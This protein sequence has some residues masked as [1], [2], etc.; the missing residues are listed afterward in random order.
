M[1]E[2]L[3]AL[4]RVRKD[5]NPFMQIQNWIKYALIYNSD[6][7][8]VSF[9]QKIMY[10]YQA[11]IIN[12]VDGDT[13][14]LEIDLGFNVKKTERIRLAR[15]DTCEM[16]SEIPFRRRK[17]RHAKMVGKKFC[18]NGSIV[19]INTFKIKIDMYA[20]YI[21]EVTFNKKNLSDYLIKQ[22]V[23]KVVF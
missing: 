8:F 17:A 18:P 14:V 12:W 19:E 22:G 7:V 11:K 20:R 10:L 15:I 23:A 5:C 9:S 4:I 3:R 1:E 13:L 6:F 16:R 21:A 2:P